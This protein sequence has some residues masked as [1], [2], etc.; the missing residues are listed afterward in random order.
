MVPVMRR[1]EA[2]V[3]GLRSQKGFSLLEALVASTVLMALSG[4]VM[5][6][7]MQVTRAQQTLWNRTEMHSGVR[8]ATEVLQQEVGQAGRI[9]LPAGAA[10]TGAVVTGNQTVG[11]TTV[12]SMFVNEWLTVDLGTNSET[13]QLTAVDAGAQQITATFARA[14]AAG[15]PLA[16]YGGFA[17]GIIPTNVANGSTGT[18][19][20]LFGDING[21]GNMMYVE[22]TCNT[23]NGNFYRNPM[24]WNAANK[25]ALTSSLILIGNLTANP[26]GTAC[27]TYQQATVGANTYVTD[28]AI[29]LTV[30]T[31]QRDSITRQF[32]VETKALL[33]I[34]PRN[35][36]NVWALASLNIVNRIQP[37]PPSVQNLLI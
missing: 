9:T 6:G 11:V 37:I 20:K 4:A 12:G 35:V 2:E 22:Y 8:S 32:Q 33:N 3:D 31:V 26:G 30:Q 28:V 23:D 36:F 7:L 16:V 21:D 13:V 1:D 5:T 19:L 18:V 15:T 17:S 29:T 24:P 14:H 25:P 34:S 27:F 10:L